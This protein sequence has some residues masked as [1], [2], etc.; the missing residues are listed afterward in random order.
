MTLTQQ[1]ELP[2][3]KRADNVIG[4]LMQIEADAYFAGDESQQVAA[5][6]A[7]LLVWRQHGYS[8]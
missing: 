3:S 8:C 1:D 2:M 5:W 6:Q 7:R 4:H